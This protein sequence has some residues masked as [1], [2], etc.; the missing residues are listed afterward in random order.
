MA[1]KI[2]LQRH[3]KKGAPF[4]HIVIADSRAPRDGRFIERIGIYNPMTNPATVDLQ[5]DRALYWL[6]VGAQPTDT[7]KALLS[8]RGV[9]YKKHL[10]RG[11]TKGALT[12]EQADAKFEAWISEKE[13]K[14]QDKINNLSTASE[15]DKTARLAAEKAVND[16]R[17]KALADAEAA[18]VAAEAPVV[19]EAVEVE[20]TPEVE[21]E[22]PAAPEADA[23][24]ETKSAE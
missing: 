13:G 17:K 24:E 5:F 1:T 15:K 2:R 3:G 11:V 14:I 23:T 6:E 12:Q 22:A 16:A 8:Y 21:A 4:Y 18:K 10:Q 7:A 20:A 9:L 19:E